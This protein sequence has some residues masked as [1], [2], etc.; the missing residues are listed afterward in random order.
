MDDGHVA[1]HDLIFPRAII[2][3]PWHPWRCYFARAERRAQF[4]CDIAAAIHGTP[5]SD[6]CSYCWSRDRDWYFASC[7]SIGLDPAASAAGSGIGVAERTAITAIT[8]I[9]A[10]RSVNLCE[11]RARKGGTRERLFHCVQSPDL[12]MEQVT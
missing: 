11:L 9:I 12:V 4:I 2:L 7:I 5:R 1:G 8:A 10:S 3:Q 6:D